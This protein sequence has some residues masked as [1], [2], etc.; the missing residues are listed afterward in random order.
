MAAKHLQ[1]VLIVGALSG[2]SSPSPEQT[3]KSIKDSTALD[4]AEQFHMAAKNGA[5]PMEQCVQAGIVKAAYL[6]AKDEK[7]YQ[8]WTALEQISCEEAGVKK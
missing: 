1:I 8:V 6:Q 7:Q 4:L 2:C 5:K 3:L